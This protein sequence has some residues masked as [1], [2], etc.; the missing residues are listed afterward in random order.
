MAE[1]PAGQGEGAGGTGPTLTS[2]RAL[3]RR[4]A[5]LGAVAWTAPVLID[6]VASPAAAASCT[7]STLDWNTITAGTG[8]TTTCSG[9]STGTTPPCTTTSYTPPAVGGVTITFT[10][11]A[12]TG[13]TLL[14]S[15]ANAGQGNL[16]VRA[17]PNGAVTT[18]AL[19]LQ[20]LPSSTS[21]GQTLT[22]SFS[23]AVTNLTFTVFD[24]DNLIGGWGDR[25]VFSPA[26]TTV[27]TTN[28]AW[29]PTTST[30]TGAGTSASPLRNT[31][32]NTN[33]AD[34]SSLGNVLLT[35]AG[36]VTTLT[37]TYT[38]AVNSGGGNMR[39][40]ISPISFCA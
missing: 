5:I 2:R 35:F 15:G 34:T 29:S 36:P 11:T 1:H 14:S 4:A 7:T 3:I 22:M 12:F 13:T 17:S 8:G 20:Q 32:T 33:F 18:R 23:R 24:I 6:S 28:A 37:L 10:S 27:T 31:S 19:Q 39:V 25:L 9:S 21:V 16:T 38:N 40:G 30:V 26:P